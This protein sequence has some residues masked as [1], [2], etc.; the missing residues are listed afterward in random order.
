MHNE[1]LSPLDLRIAF[2]T[3]CFAA[4]ARE[5]ANAIP[6]I[7]PGAVPMFG[8]FSQALCFQ[9]EENSMQERPAKVSEFVPLFHYA[10]EW[11]ESRHVDVSFESILHASELILIHQS[12]LKLPRPLED[13]KP[14]FKEMKSTINAAQNAL[15]LSDIR[16]DFYPLRFDTPKAK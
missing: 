13:L 11:L 14:E 3:N 6:N 8:F 7:K 2:G 4:E 1:I 9:D 12:G 15:L 10:I 16:K 5:I